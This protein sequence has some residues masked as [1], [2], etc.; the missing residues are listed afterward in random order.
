MYPAFV[1]HKPIFLSI[2]LF[3]KSRARKEVSFGYLFHVLVKPCPGRCGHCGC[4]K[5]ATQSI[6]IEPAYRPGVPNSIAN[7]LFFFDAPNVSP[8]KMITFSILCLFKSQNLPLQ[9][10]KTSCNSV[11][12][13]LW[14]SSSLTCS[15]TIL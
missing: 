15:V 5:A 6:S 11:I 8:R 13:L 4:Q 10:V 12:E 7:D 14:K 3:W 2:H 9:V 1:L